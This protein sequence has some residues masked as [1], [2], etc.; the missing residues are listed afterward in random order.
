MK[1]CWKLK[2]YFEANGKNTERSP[3]F[4]F[5]FFCAFQPAGR[6]FM[7]LMPNRCTCFFGA[8]F[9]NLVNRHG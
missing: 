7:R 5:A 6:P 9:F 4:S 2:N 8:W 1:K 3:F